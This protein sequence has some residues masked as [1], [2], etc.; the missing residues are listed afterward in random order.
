VFH[1]WKKS[2]GVGTTWGWVFI[3]R[4]F[5]FGWTNLTNHRCQAFCEHNRFLACN[6]FCIFSYTYNKFQL[7]CVNDSRL[8]GMKCRSCNLWHAVLLWGTSR[9]CGLQRSVDVY[10]RRCCCC[11]CCASASINRSSHRD[12]A[13]AVSLLLTV[14]IW[15]PGSGAHGSTQALIQRIWDPG[16]LA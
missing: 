16:G 2:Y 7:Q 6:P 5:V 15:N 3:D 13:G 14:F 11:C 4:I 1:R 8:I 12:M 9:A 10:S